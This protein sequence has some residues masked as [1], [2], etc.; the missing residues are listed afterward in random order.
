MKKQKSELSEIERLKKQ[1]KKILKK[2]KSK[3]YKE[4]LQQGYQL[5]FEEHESLKELEN[6]EQPGPAH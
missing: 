2:E 1:F 6:Y 4:G 5:G 3:S